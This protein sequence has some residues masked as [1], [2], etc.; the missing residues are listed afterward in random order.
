M[1]MYVNVY[2]KGKK[3]RILKVILREKS[4][5]GEQKK[6]F[7]VNDVIRQEGIMYT[8]GCV[9]FSDYLCFFLMYAHCISI[10]KGWFA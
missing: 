9:F 1:D 2:R 3:K 5:S 4:E 6:G 7:L 8:S 10:Q